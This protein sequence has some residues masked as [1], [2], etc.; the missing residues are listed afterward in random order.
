[1]KKS[2]HSATVTY[3]YAEK[4]IPFA[5]MT[6]FF[7]DVDVYLPKTVKGVEIIKSSIIGSF[8]LM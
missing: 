4:A 7:Y 6:F 5:R 1:M 8:F 3:R 2:S